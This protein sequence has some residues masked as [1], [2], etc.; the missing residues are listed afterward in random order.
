VNC[1]FCEVKMNKFQGIRYCPNPNCG[2]EITD[3]NVNRVTVHLTTGNGRKRSY[4]APT[5]LDCFRQFW[6]DLAEHKSPD[7]W[8][9]DGAEPVAFIPATVDWFLSKPGRTIEVEIE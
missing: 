1:P 8:E 2:C 5:L 3:G 7:Q 6:L 4:D 9:P